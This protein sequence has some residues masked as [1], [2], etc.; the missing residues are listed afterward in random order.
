MR[1][2]TI[3]EC[4][5]VT[6]IYSNMRIVSHPIGHIVQ[7]HVTEKKLFKCAIGHVDFFSFWSR[8]KIFKSNVCRHFCLTLLINS[9]KLMNVFPTFMPRST[10]RLTQTGLLLLASTR[11]F[12]WQYEFAVSS[13]M[14]TSRLMACVV[15]ENAKYAQS[16]FTLR[17]VVCVCKLL[18]LSKV[19]IIKGWTYERINRYCCQFWWESNGWY[20]QLATRFL[21]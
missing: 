15:I 8:C 2:H 14:G 11:C 17:V 4:V 12:V 20:R 18:S 3:L 16:V 5:I 7:I 21:A 19:S 6:D 10:R 9:D 1:W 13:S